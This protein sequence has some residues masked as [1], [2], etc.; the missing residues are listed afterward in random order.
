MSFKD[1]HEA[2]WKLLAGEVATVVEV[3]KN[4]NGTIFQLIN[5]GGLVSGWASPKLFVYEK[6]AQLCTSRQ[7]LAGDKVIS[8]DGA[9]RNMADKEPIFK[10]SWALHV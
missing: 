4:S 3:S 1:G 8:F 6:E 10:R 7:P 9:L 5:P 2:A